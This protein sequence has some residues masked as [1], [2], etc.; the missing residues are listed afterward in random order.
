MT[1]TFQVEGIAASDAA[2]GAADSV[3]DRLVTS[4]R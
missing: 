2:G 3:P 4:S 1:K